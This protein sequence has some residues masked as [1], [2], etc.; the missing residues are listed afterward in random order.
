MKQY[1]YEL[2]APRKNDDLIVDRYEQFYDTEGNLAAE[3]KPH[4]L[5][6]HPGIVDPDWPRHIKAMAKAKHVPTVVTLY[7]SKQAVQAREQALQQAEADYKA[8]SKAANKTAKDKAKAAATAA[9]T[10]RD[11]AQAAS[12]AFEAG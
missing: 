9:K 6:A 5:C 11:E 2:H 8:D 7:Q 4:T 3:G 1:R 12:D 10:A